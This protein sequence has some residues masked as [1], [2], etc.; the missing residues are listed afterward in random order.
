M[1]KTVFI[2][3]FVALATSVFA[4]APIQG[5][6]GG[7]KATKKT[8]AKPVTTLA[9]TEYVSIVPANVQRMPLFA[10]KIHAE[11]LI[12][13]GQLGVE[14]IALIYTYDEEQAPAVL[15]IQWNVSTGIW[16]KKLT[17][18]FHDLTKPAVVY[19]LAVK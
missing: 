7:K 14:R 16:E 6:K 13:S 15:A 12:N 9:G 1:K 5:K 8:A 3:A 2:I 17:S 18:D 19:T 4:T 11:K 10:A